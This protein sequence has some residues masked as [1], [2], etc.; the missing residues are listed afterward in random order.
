MVWILFSFRKEGMSS[1]WNEG[2]VTLSH[3]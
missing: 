2:S 3:Y 1:L